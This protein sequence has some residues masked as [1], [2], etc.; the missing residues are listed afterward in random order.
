MF[1]DFTHSHQANAGVMSRAIFGV[2][3]MTCIWSVSFNSYIAINM[4]VV[5]YCVCLCVLDLPVYSSVCYMIIQFLK[6]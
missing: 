3:G 5:S 6:S 2:V 4:S 1:Y